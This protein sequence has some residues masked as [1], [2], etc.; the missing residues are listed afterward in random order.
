MLHGIGSASPKIRLD[1]II[2]QTAMRDFAG[3]WSHAPTG[4]RPEARERNPCPGKVHLIALNGPR[5]DVTASNTMGKLLSAFLAVSL[6]AFSA[7]PFVGTWK[8][9]VEKSKL[10]SGSP[11]WRKTQT[12]TV[13]WLGKTSSASRTRTWLELQDQSRHWNSSWT[14]RNTK[15]TTE[16]R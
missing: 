13:E 15:L 1:S 9:N 14:G 8:P 3:T 7:D 4:N 11:E 2:P 10:S 16:S 12:L 6:S 5:R